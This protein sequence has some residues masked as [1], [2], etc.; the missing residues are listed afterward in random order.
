MR[1]KGGFVN[2]VLCRENS[3]PILIVIISNYL[4]YVICKE[5]CLS[6]VLSACIISM[7]CLYNC[8]IL[9]L[10]NASI[11]IHVWKKRDLIIIIFENYIVKQQ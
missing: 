5:I 2:K 4:I 9:I 6:I 1:L 7:M 11:A 3:L 8:N 10:K